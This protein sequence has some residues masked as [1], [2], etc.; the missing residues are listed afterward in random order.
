MAFEVND[1]VAGFPFGVMRH[2]PNVEMKVENGTLRIRSTRTAICYRGEHAPFLKGADGFVDTGDIIELRDD[3]Y[4][5]VGRRDGV[6]NVGGLKVH[7]EEMEAVINRHPEVHM[8][9]VRAKKNPMIGSLVVADVCSDSVS[10][11]RRR[12]AGPAKRHP[13]VL[14]RNIVFHKVPQ[15][16]KFR[17][18]PGGRESGKMMRRNA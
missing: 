18:R 17:S 16:D 1:G 11:R 7:P 9:L 15:L 5:F 10:D 2:T 13:D 12:C 4:Y 3:R 8:S 14:P 6:I